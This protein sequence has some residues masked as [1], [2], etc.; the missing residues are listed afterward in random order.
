LG[1]TAL[2]LI[3]EIFV[4]YK[5]YARLL[6]Y[7]A[8]SL[9]AYILTAFIVKQ[10]WTKVLYE[11]FIPSFSFNRDYLMNIVAILGT[12]ISP[13]MFFWQA[14]EEIEEEQEHCKVILTG[15]CGGITNITFRDVQDMRLIPP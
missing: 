12:T 13:Y 10:D 1:L 5:N 7:L 11:T 2:I 15:K 9:I 4:S 8:F 6:K 14:N 3:L